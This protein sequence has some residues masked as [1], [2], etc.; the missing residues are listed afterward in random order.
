MVMDMWHD[1]LDWIRRK[2]V[3]P[4]AEDTEEDDDEVTAITVN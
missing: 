2:P 3:F 1:D 4:A